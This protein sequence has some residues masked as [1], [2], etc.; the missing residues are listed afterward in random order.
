MIQVML[1]LQD[2]SR[3]RQSKRVPVNLEDDVSE[4]QESIKTAF[5]I[6]IAQQIISYVSSNFIVRVV[7]G[8]Q[9]KFFEVGNNQIIDV[10]TLDQEKEQVTAPIQHNELEEDEES[11]DYQKKVDF[12]NRL[13]TVRPSALDIIEES[14]EDNTEEDKIIQ[15]LKKKLQNIIK[16]KLVNRI[17]EIISDLSRLEHGLQLQIIED[18]DKVGWPAPLYAVAND[19]SLLISKFLELFGEELLNITSRE[20]MTPLFLAVSQKNW[21][22]VWSML[23]FAKKKHFEHENSNGWLQ[24]LFFAN[25]PEDLIEETI[26]AGQ[27][28]PEATSTRGQSALD[29]LPAAQKEKAMLMASVRKAPDCPVAIAG[30]VQKK[31]FFWGWADRWLLINLD[32]KVLERYGSPNDVPYSPREVLPLHSLESLSISNSDAGE[33]SMHF[34]EFD[35]FKEPHVYKVRL[36]REAKLWETAL[37]RAID[38]A[39]FYDKFIAR[40]PDPVLRAKLERI[41]NEKNKI[42]DPVS[43]AKKENFIEMEK[44]LLGESSKSGS[45]ARASLKD[46]D[47]LMLLGKG[48][49]GKVYKVRHKGTGKIY[50]M[51][52]LLKKNL[53]KMQQIKYSIIEKE[54]LASNREDSFLLSLHFAFQT[55]DNLF[56]VI[57]FCPHGDL[58]IVLAQQENG[59]FSEDVIRFYS[60]E[61]FL[62][63]EELHARNYIYRD[64]KPE[65]VLIDSEG[66]AR[67]ADF[68]LA[69]EGIKSPNDFAKSFAGSPIYLS[70]EMIKNRRTYKV[71]DFYSIGVMIY[72][73]ATGEPPF[74][75]DDINKLYALIK[76]G[77]V[78]FPRGQPVRLSRELE[79]LITK[80]MRTDPK[81]RLGAA[82]GVAE[83]KEHEFFKG[84]NWELISKKAIS[85]PLN[86][87]QNPSEPNS[88]I[89]IKDREYGEG[90]KQFYIENFDF[91]R[92]QP[93]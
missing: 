1:R 28:D 52:C 92:E 75:S 78:K 35:Y 51:K 4:L 18:P 88:R 54:I 59:H 30:P 65:N 55:I 27:C 84:L 93:K 60:A 41:W 6:P 70:P 79:D 37:T 7:P 86:F 58:S 32:S 53:F 40:R 91:I 76:K 22:M 74:I 21:P 56:M 5:G 42:V 81:T 20:G 62:A 64:M 3:G 85:P 8:F 68:G 66:H 36:E 48:A 46:F 73:L 49:F 67:V 80:L 15:E 17:P 2:V 10:R 77:D 25:A 83:I 24:S 69:A 29:F 16:S 44:L 89:I 23:P 39:K 26:L 11:K 87:A 63:V 19:F 14:N 9:L 72:E 61:I 71:S 45:K 57:D 50:A 34:I 90:P 38:W 47:I 13:R 31:S 82:R 43:I 33:K 12:I